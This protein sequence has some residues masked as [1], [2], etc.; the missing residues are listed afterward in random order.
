MQ[1]DSLINPLGQ[2]RTQEWP[3]DQVSA[4]Q[5]ADMPTNFISVQEL[6]VQDVQQLESSP[7]SETEA[8]DPVISGNQEAATSETGNEARSEPGNE[9][10]SPEA[11]ASNEAT[12]TNAGIASF[13]L[14]DF[15]ELF[16]VVE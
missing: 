1:I 4:P 5:S 16:E 6:V 9:T 7:S 11:S 14:Q 13:C 10:G 2:F 15:P 3:A 8:Q 12:E